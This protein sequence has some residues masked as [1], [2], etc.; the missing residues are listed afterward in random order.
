MSH[1]LCHAGCFQYDAVALL[2]LNVYK[3]MTISTVTRCCLFGLFESSLAACR[4]VCMRFLRFAG[5]YT[6]SQLDLGEGFCAFRRAGCKVAQR[7]FNPL[8]LA[9]FVSCGVY[10]IGCG[11]RFLQDKSFLLHFFVMHHQLGQEHGGGAPVT[12]TSDTRTRMS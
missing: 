7:S 6:N 2:E 5:R 10:L 9:L 11:P 8:D 12:L 3:C 1:L 4:N